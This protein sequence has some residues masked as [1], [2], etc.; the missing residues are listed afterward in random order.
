[1]STVDRHL[2]EHDHLLQAAR[3]GNGAAFG[4]LAEAYRPYLKTVASRV[5]GDR[6]PS[7]GSDV[8]QAGLSMAFAHLAQFRDREPAAFLGWLA[9]IV[10]N[11]ARRYLRQAGRLQPLP[12][13]PISDLLAGSSSGPDARAARREQAAGV[14]A[15]VSRLPEDYRTVIE[16]RNLQERPFEEVARLMGRSNAAVRKLWTRA[17]DRLRQELGDEL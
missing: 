4:R 7:D 2:P 5:L 14:L 1:M 10:R 8:V 9:T 16:L 3:A 11:E 6:L 13:S 15:A 17:M 12:E